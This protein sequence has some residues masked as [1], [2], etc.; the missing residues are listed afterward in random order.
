[1]KVLRP[2]EWDVNYGTAVAVAE[3]EDL[4]PSGCLR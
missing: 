2:L 1:M 3:R 4:P